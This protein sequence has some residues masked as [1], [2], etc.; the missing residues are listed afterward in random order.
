MSE[1]S[2]FEN[3]ALAALAARLE[4]DLPDLMIEWADAVR[5]DP[6]IAATDH[7]TLTM[8]RDH[9]PQML[10]ELVEMLRTP[11]ADPHVSEVREVGREHGKTRWR[12]GYRLDEMLRELA[13]MRTLVLRRASG[14]FS[15]LLPADRE[16]CGEVVAEF[17]DTVAAASAREFVHAQEAET[18]LRSR[19]LQNAYEQV[20]AA[21]AEWQ[22][23]ARSRLGLLRGV[24]HE[25]KN[26]L[27]A[28]ALASDALVDESDL[29]RRTSAG[30]ELR[31]SAVRLQRLLDR[32]QELS[33]IL[34][35]EARVEPER[36]PLPPFLVELEGAY[37]PAADRKG[38][39]LSCSTATGPL[40]VTTDRAKLRA[41]AD[42]LIAN[43]IEF[44]EHGSVRVTALN[45]APGRW[46]LRVEDTGIGID[47][48]SREL[49][50]S[51]FHG[52]ASAQHAGLGL[53]L[54]A[55]RHLAH[56]MDGEITFRSAP[57]EGSCFELNLPVDFDVGNY[58][59]PP[60]S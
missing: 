36:L 25:L 19:Q 40:S 53:G 46:I 16:R 21:T 13:R 48:S 55:A 37:R 52:T 12:H 9:F 38:L 58:A 27:Q 24:S 3:Q 59:S 43:A 51:E 39:A 22:A 28:L 20:Q 49:I 35:N 29:K 2:S 11:A 8:L 33:A 18:L 34:A 41:I 57:G 10:G 50:F 26:V 23:V 17:F 45:D 5:D 54:V 47:E 15:M 56:L 6:E 60:K 7:L 4:A 31:V 30:Y 44:T 14:W 42:S 1:E 32:L